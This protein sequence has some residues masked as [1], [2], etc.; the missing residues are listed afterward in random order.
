MTLNALESPKVVSRTDWLA[1]R[2]EL[3]AQEKELTHARDRLSAQR[4]ELPWVKVEQNYS[5]DTPAGRKTLADLFDG[6]SQLIVYHFMWRGDLNDACVGCSFLT[7]HMD[8]ANLHLAE[9]DVTLT[10]VSRA[11]LSILERF[12]QRMGWRFNWVS[13]EGSDFNYDYHVSFR[14]EEI[15]SGH[16]YYN[17]R[18]TQA[19]IEELSGFSVFYKDQQGDVFHTYS[20]YGR[21]NEEV[22]GAYMY[23]DLTPKGRNE[24]G[25]NHNLTDW[26]RHHDRYGIGGF[27]DSTGGYV[28]GQNLTCCSHSMMDASKGNNQTPEATATDPVVAELCSFIERRA[29]A[30][31]SKNLETAAACISFDVILFDVVD[32]LQYGGADELTKRARQWFSSFEGPI[33][34]EMRQLQV[35]TCQNMGFSHSLNRVNATRID[36][37]KLE[38]WWRST[39][40]Y[41]KTEGAWKVTHEHNSVPF[42]PETGKATLDLE[43]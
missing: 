30:V 36:G 21:G 14:P 19:S 17:Y 1:A 22:L 25:P 3:L 26:V 18:L 31:R 12:K 11:P 20:S 2:E 16:V 8:G 13:S 4:R 28:S 32:Q 9:H 41:S 15:A 6:R 37:Q 10:V 38:M 39:T 40:C 24:T 35:T 33:G 29:E 42:N 34:F 5:F 7:D 27:V 43:P 23:L